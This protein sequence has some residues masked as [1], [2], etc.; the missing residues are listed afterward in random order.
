MTRYCH[1]ATDCSRAR[2]GT[3]PC[4]SA[5]GA[6]LLAVTVA[7]V[8]G[9]ASADPYTQ[10][11]S[12]IN[13]LQG[14]SFQDGGL[15]QDSQ[16]V[17]ANNGSSQSSAAGT[18]LPSCLSPDSLHSQQCGN[19]AASASSF[20]DFGHIGVTANASV[21]GYS[22]GFGYVNADAWGQFSDTLV[23][24]SNSL[25]IG[26]T[27]QGILELTLDDLLGAAG[28]SSVAGAFASY[29][30]LIGEVD[31]NG[32]SLSFCRYAEINSSGP[33]PVGCIFETSTSLDLLLPSTFVVGQTLQLSST[34][35]SQAGGQAGGNYLSDTDSGSA[36][37]FVSAGH[38]TLTYLTA[39][40]DFSFVSQSGH[41]YTPPSVATVPEPST[42]WLLAIAMLGL[43]PTYGKCRRAGA[44]PS[45]PRSG[46]V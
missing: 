26:T 10:A 5:F 46:F 2:A 35:S 44:K 14:F 27:V 16:S 12:G 42:C 17:Q 34:L 43:F 41:D 1:F 40:G 18:V 45:V 4:G 8:A 30:W 21:Y 9:I 29:A 33:G 28:G 7:A 24:T 38:T 11:N 39:L 6:L 19:A 23:V 20:A 13:I 36:S 25:P 32:M 3:R 37:G 22:A 15:T 31:L